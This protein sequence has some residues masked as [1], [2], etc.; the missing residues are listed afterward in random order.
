[1]LPDRIAALLRPFLDAPLPPSV[2]EQISTYVDL[3]SRWNARVNLTAIREPDE[4]VT[5]HFGESIFLARHLFPRQDSGTRCS[6]LPS[7]APRVLDIGSGSG[8]PGLPLKMWAPEIALTLVE[9]N[10]K[11]GAFLR[12]V[13]RTLTLTNVNVNVA[14]AETLAASA[15]VVTFR[16]VERFESILPIAIRLLAPSGQLALLV[17]ASQLPALSSCPIAWSPPIPIPNSSARVLAI[18]ER[19]EKVE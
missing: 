4:I 8:F 13:A 19:T 18:G 11:K 9:S 7:G 15:D 16:A 6:P 5:R 17:G 3:L 12:E 14:R 2:L 10:H 1:M